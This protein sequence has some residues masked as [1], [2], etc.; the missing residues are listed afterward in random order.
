MFGGG[1]EIYNFKPVDVKDSDSSTNYSPDELAKGVLDKTNNPVTNASAI[2]PDAWIN[3]GGS[4]V[5]WKDLLATLQTKTVASGQTFDQV[6]QPGDVLKQQRVVM[7]EDARTLA[8]EV[9]TLKSAQPNSATADP[10]IETKVEQLQNLIRAIQ[11]ANRILSQDPNTGIEPKW[12][13]EAGMSDGK[14]SNSNGS[15]GGQFK[16]TYTP[17]ANPWGGQQT[18]KGIYNGAGGGVG[19]NGFNMLDGLQAPSAAAYANSAYLD[20]MIS[21]GMAGLG[22]ASREGQRL[23]MLFFYYARMAMSG[24]L[25]AMYQ[26]MKFITHII[27]KDKAAQNVKISTKLI[28]LQDMSR[29]ATETLMAT[30]S[31]DPDKQNDF[32]KA[33]QKAK[34]DETMISTSQK[35]LADMLQEFAQVVESVI[36]MTKNTQDAKG[37]VERKITGG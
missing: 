17:P 26:F 35:L 15:S 28:E 10:S 29:K 3:F 33:M 37:R 32:V 1:I 2:N 11:N 24:D 14:E 22:K 34:S 4:L 16:A 30:P 31:D 12:F 25:G 20:T 21:D 13:E 18:P 36:S 9:A 8:Q 23:M 27:S 7:V 19:G 5:R 6:L